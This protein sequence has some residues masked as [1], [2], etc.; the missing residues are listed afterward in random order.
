MSG[1]GKNSSSGSAYK[2]QRPKGKKNA[3]NGE[4]RVDG[5]LPNLWVCEFCFKY[6]KDGTML[7]LHSV[8]RN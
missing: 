6:M 8:R 1:S 5:P 4:L 7:D 2:K 3:E